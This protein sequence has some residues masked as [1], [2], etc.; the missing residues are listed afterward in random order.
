MEL[1]QKNKND[2]ANKKK[3]KIVVMWKIV[4]A[5]KVSVLYIYRLYCILFTYKKDMNKDNLLFMCLLVFIFFG[6]I[7]IEP[8]IE[9]SFR[10]FENS[11]PPIFKELHFFNP[12][13]L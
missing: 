7:L 10:K 3:K 8:F 13:I 5:P 11:N 9:F 6:Y 12:T 1:E 4:G 2:V